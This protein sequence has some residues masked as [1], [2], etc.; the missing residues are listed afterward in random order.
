MTLLICVGVGVLIGGTIGGVG[1]TGLLSYGYIVGGSML[2]YTSTSSNNQPGSLKSQV[3][4][5]SAKRYPNSGKLL[6]SKMPMR[7][8]RMPGW[9]G[10]TKYQTSFSGNTVHYVGN[11]YLNGWWSP[12]NIWFDYKFSVGGN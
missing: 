9:L 3:V 1:V 6:R 4:M 2:P 5:N 8:P 10:W 7:D 11:R 12:N